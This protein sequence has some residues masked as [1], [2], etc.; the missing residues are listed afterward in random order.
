MFSESG[1]GPV[2]V[3]ESA[4]ESRSA[5]LELRRAAMRRQVSQTATGMRLTR[6]HDDHRALA[7][8]IKV[9]GNIDGI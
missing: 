3:E 7:A 8:L 9:R 1:S 2:C 6:K 5:R 4:A